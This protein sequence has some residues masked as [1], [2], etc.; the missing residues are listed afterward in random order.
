MA[1]VENLA[2][3]LFEAYGRRDLE[4]MRGVLAAR[5]DFVKER[6][7]ALR[8]VGVRV[9]GEGVPDIGDDL[10]LEVGNCRRRPGEDLL[11]GV[12]LALLSN[13]QQGRCLDPSKL[14]IR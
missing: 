7:D 13:Q 6:A 10:G 12:D 2:R 1:D 11:G 4:A 9:D 5:L 14:L 3:S 8:G